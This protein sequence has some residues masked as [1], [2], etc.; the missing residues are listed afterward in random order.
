MQEQNRKGFS[1]GELVML[2]AVVSVAGAILVPVLAQSADSA[3]LER[4]HDAARDTLCLSN[5]KQIGTAMRMYQQ[6][7][8]ER[9]PKATLAKKGGYNKHNIDSY[10]WSEAILPYVKDKEIYQCPSEK[11]AGQ[12]DSMKPGYTDY[13]LNSNVSG[14]LLENIKSPATLLVAGDG[15]GGSPNSNARYN[16]S[17]LPQGWITTA[18]SPA[19]R[20]HDSAIY[21][22]A[23]GHVKKLTP[24]QVGSKQATFKVK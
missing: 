8:D 23:D 17:S 19:R 3:S 6:D 2:G 15:D 14:V 5:L 4:A 24:A 10:G 13:W 12:S 9:M 7:F 18:N 1:R 20:H 16:L 11:H 22:F 21:A